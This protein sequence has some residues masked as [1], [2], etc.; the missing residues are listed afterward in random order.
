MS[1]CNVHHYVNLDTSD[2]SVNVQ[3]RGEGWDS[4][5]ILLIFLANPPL[6]VGQIRSEA[7]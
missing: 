5:F 7:V 6:E 1:V 2:V 4:I 3:E